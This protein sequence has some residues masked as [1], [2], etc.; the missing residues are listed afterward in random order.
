MINQ[1]NEIAG[2][3]PQRLVCVF[4]NAEIYFNSLD[5]NT[6]IGFCPAPQRL[7]SSRGSWSRRR[8]R[9]PPSCRNFARRIDAKSS[10]RKFAG[11]STSGIS[12]E[13]FGR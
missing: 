10:L 2:R 3:S 12:K 11:G 13:I 8:P 4:G 9:K 7:Q 5:A 1:G 6:R